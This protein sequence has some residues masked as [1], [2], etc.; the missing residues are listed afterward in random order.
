MI[1]MSFE[2]DDEHRARENMGE[3]VVQASLHALR[4]KRENMRVN[5]VTCL[6]VKSLL[7]YRISLFVCEA[8]SNRESRLRV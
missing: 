6:C 8:S 1:V 4:E 3:R 2:K 5:A 7:V